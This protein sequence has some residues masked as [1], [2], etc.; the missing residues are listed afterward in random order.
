M[1]K[2]LLL[3]PFLSLLAF[4]QTY[5]PQTIYGGTSNITASSTATINAGID[6]RKQK[7][8]G[9]QVQF[10][11]SG[12]GTDNQVLTFERSLDGSN[13]ETL[14]ANKH[15]ITVAATGATESVTIDEIDCK[16]AGYLRLASWQNGSSSRY[17]TNVV[18]K[19]AL[20]INAP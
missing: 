9:V 13:W 20:K 15:T 2:F 12:S 1:K 7:K 14:A 6:C 16:G 19:Y 10:K 8:V 11:L 5:S 18:V 3:I 4:G 17:T